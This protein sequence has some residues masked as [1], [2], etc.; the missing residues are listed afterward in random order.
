MRKIIEQAFTVPFR[1]QVCF[2]ENI[3]DRNNGTLARLLN[4]GKKA[5]AFFVVDE[6]PSPSV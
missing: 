6:G 1:Y 3:F 5:K 2:T 4:N